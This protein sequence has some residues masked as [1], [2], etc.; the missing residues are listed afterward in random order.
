VD[1]RACVHVVQSLCVMHVCGGSVMSDEFVKCVCGRERRGDR[2][3]QQQ[4]V[5]P[6]TL[7]PAPS[8]LSR[9]AMSFLW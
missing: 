7:K 9:D 6:T 2:K 3:V 5:V 8:T 1:V 4:G